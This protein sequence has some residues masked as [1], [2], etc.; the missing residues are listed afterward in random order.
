M[1]SVTRLRVYFIII[2]VVIVIIILLAT[3]F[4]LKKLTSGTQKN[5]EKPVPRW[6]VAGPSR[7]LTSSQQ[8]GN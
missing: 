5:Q 6:P 7:I 3:S 2:I 4:G 1:H 8:S